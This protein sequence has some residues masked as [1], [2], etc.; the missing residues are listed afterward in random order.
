MKA[1]PPDGWQARVRRLCGDAPSAVLY[2]EERELLLDVFTGK[3]VPVDWPHLAAMHERKNAETG[4]PY[5]VLAR[6][7]GRQLVL[8]EV[9]IAFAPSTAAS[10]PIPE[11]PPVVCFRDLAGAEARLTHF[12]VEHADEEPN[13]SHVALFLFCLAVVDGARAVG[14]EVG[15]E[16]RRLQ[17]ILGELE[18]RRRAGG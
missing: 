4:R 18:A 1:I 10:G 11:L 8:A 12:L 16:E 17:R 13:P 15:P 7:D 3:S 6:D 9:G 14:F 5:L 2:D